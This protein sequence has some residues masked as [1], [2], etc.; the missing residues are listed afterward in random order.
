MT[1]VD[2]LQRKFGKYAVPSIHRYL[3]FAVFIGYVLDFLG[4]RIGI[5][6]TSFLSFNVNAILHLQIW[7][8]VTWVFC[9]PPT[10]GTFMTI[11]FLLCLIPMGRSLES[12][13]GTFKMNLYIIGGIIISDIGGFLAY[14][15]IWLA[16]GQGIG[17][18]LSA[19]HILLTIFMGLALCVPDATVNLYF[20]LP[21]KMKW[22]LIVYF[23]ELAYEVYTY[24]SYGFSVANQGYDLAYGMAIAFYYSTEI[25]CALV[26]LGVF[27]LFVR[28]P[29]SRQ[30]KKRRKQF[31]QQTAGYGNRSG[32]PGAAA[33]YPGGAHHKCAICGRTELDDPNLV[34]R[35]CSKCVGNWEYCQDHLFTHEHKK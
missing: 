10:S 35:Y 27:F 13:L 11:L 29:M 9:P 18:Y 7:R 3:V 6:I 19:Y 26:N 30:Q 1:W 8:L 16:L 28:N 23:A 17:A 4:D 32:G 24:F 14:G 21:I 25:I 33:R 5:S 34:F 15:I 31:Q 22:M 12:F 2:K 20:V